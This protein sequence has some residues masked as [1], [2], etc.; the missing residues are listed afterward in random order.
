LDFTCRTCGKRHDATAISFG[1]DA[2]VQWALVSDEDRSRSELGG[3]QC[4]IEADGQRHFFVRA[5]LEIPIKGTQRA[6]TWGVWVSL[7][8]KSFLEMSDHW[9]DPSRATVGPYFGWLCTKIPEYPDTVF[10]KTMVHQRAIGQRPIV[11]L[12]ETDHP[13]SI[14][15]RNGVDPERMQEII[16]KVLHSGP[17]EELTQG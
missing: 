7:S 12:E 4:V 8:E 5:C 3:E 13:L 9:E 15:Q 6:F 16:S 2:P 1:A 14:D 17:S 11:Q 10:L